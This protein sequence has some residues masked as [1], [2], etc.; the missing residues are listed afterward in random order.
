MLEKRFAE[1]VKKNRLVPPGSKIL[2]AASGGPDSSALVL[3]IGKYRALF[4]IKSAEFVYFDHGI[5]PRREIARDVAVV[6]KL[7]AVTGF[8]L[9]VVKLK[10][11]S[12]GA[13][14]ENK[15]REARYGALEKIARSGRFDVVMTAHT[16]DDNAETLLMR[17]VRGTGLKGLGGIAPL[18][19]FVDGI[20]LVRPLV[21]FRKKELLDFLRRRG[22]AYSSDSTNRDE[23]FFR[24]AVRRR[25][26]PGLESLNP[27]VVGHLS[28]LSR[29]LACD[30]DFMEAAAARAYGRA[31]SDGVLDLKKFF[32]YN[33]SVRNRIINMWLG[34]LNDFALTRTVERFLSDSSA[35]KIAAGGV[36]LKKHLNLVKF[37]ST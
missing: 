36:T 17:M 6:K 23:R 25:I 32:R 18:R 8:S 10:I 27:A 15:A 7:S 22:A 12:R 14:V 1:T 24:N 13:S 33:V 3:L 16:A 9:S 11:P 30:S 4:K 29:S 5:R 20:T 2:I 28:N 37:I 21:F 35:K 19:P 34:D 31:V 26:M